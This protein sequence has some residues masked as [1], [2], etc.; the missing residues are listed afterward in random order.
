M[1]IRTATEADAAALCRYAEALFAEDLPGIFH[2][3]APTVE[4]EIEFVRSHAEPTNSTLLIAE[5]DGEIIG[6]I[7]FMGGKRD[8]ERHAG[9]FGISVSK[10]HRG[11]GIGTA[12][13]EAL[14]DWAPEGGVSRIECYS[15]ANNPG[16]ARLY[17]RMGFVEE[18]R[19]RR[20]IV[21]DGETIDVL[22]LARLFPQTH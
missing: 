16:S 9:E 17:R 3:E 1:H 11:Q 2:R 14:V 15:W 19:M 22:L 6:V 13:I 7:G 4:E 12:L 10:A 21:R 18:G 5:R 20:A 8:E